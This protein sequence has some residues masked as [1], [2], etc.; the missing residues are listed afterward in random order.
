M[1]SQGTDR[2]CQLMSQMIG[3]EKLFFSYGRNGKFN[4]SSKVYWVVQEVIL[5][6]LDPRILYLSHYFVL[7]GKRGGRIMYDSIR[8]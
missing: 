4:R 6:A 1:A 2:F 8:R 5:E 7:E 3:R